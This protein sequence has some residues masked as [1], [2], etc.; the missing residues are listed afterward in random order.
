MP[1]FI[2]HNK[3][4]FYLINF[5]FGVYYTLYTDLKFKNFGIVTV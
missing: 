4:L 2:S 3:I 1:R 5:Y